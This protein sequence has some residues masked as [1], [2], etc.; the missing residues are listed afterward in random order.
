MVLEQEE[1]QC[2]W[3]GGSWGHIEGLAGCAEEFHSCGLCVHIIQVLCNIVSKPLVWQ[4]LHLN[5]VIFL[6]YRMGQNSSVLGP[7]ILSFW[8]W[9]VK[10]NFISGS[11]V[12]RSLTGMHR[13]FILNLSLTTSTL[14]AYKMVIIF[15]ILSKNPSLHHPRATFLGL[16]NEKIVLLSANSIRA[17]VATENNKVWNTLHW[18]MN[19]L[20]LF[21]SPFSIF[22]FCLSK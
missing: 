6:L 13:Y 11:G 1:G 4:L 18:L 17:T 22:S 16:T 15:L 3:R 10:E 21:S 8:L 19:I 12:N 9:A 20:C 14:S 2:D 5:I 7:Y